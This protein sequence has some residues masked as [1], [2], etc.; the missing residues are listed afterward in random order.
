M[1][2]TYV[3]NFSVDFSTESHIA[4][5]WE[6]LGH[7]VQ[8]IPEQNLEWADLPE[9][10]EGELFTWTR[11]A[12]FDPPDL[13]RQRAAL[14]GID[15]PKVGIHLDRWWGLRREATERGPRDS[16]PSPF[17]THLDLL[18]TADGGDHP[19][20]VR[21][22][23]MPPAILSDEARIGTVRKQYVA[24]VAF[25]GNLQDYGHEEWRT[26]RH[27]L[28]GKLRQW[29][30]G[31]FQVFPGRGRPQIRGQDLADLYA[32]VKVCVGD[33]CLAGN[34]THYWSDRVPETL[35]RGGFLIHP[36]VEPIAEHYPDLPTYPLGD[37]ETL[38]E[39]IQYAL[40]HPDWRSEV[41]ERNRKHVLENHTY[42]PRM[43][44]L[45]ELV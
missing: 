24:D 31:R 11:T 28:W 26:Y 43:A 10:V 38:R 22:E 4:K 25:V 30:H 40:G 32:S 27:Q 3:G 37:F 9:L 13:D 29:H 39:M 12:G 7:D 19:W 21:H 44:R 45:L 16:D 35:G 41:A 5:A 8:R 14:S 36:Q 6:N 34:P 15:Q 18:Y 23:W 42:E 2:L 20:A 1:R 33:S 17:F